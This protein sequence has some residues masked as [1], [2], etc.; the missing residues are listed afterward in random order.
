[1]KL[2]FVKRHLSITAFPEIEVPHFTVVLGINGSGKSHLLQA[3]ANGSV[4][5]DVVPFPTEHVAP[6]PIPNLIKLMTPDQFKINEG[7]YTSQAANAGMFTPFES[8]RNEILAPFLAQLEQQGLGLRKGLLDS[9]E[10]AWRVGASE[11]I[12]RGGLPEKSVEIKAIFDAAANAL[13]E[14]CNA[15]SLPGRGIARVRS[16]YLPQVAR[17][18]SKLKTSALKISEDHIRQFMP[19]TTDQFQPNLA[20]VFGKYR[21]AF[22]RNRLLRLHDIDSGN[23]NSLSDEKFVEHFG[24]PPWD[25]ISKTFS[26]FGLPYVAVAPDLFSV[27]PVTFSIAKVSSAERVAIGNMS[28][29]ERILFQFA[30]AMFHYDEEVT[31]VTR[32]KLL[33]LD[34]MDAP[35]HPEMVNRWLGAVSG[36]LVAQQGVSCILTTHSPTTIALAPEAALYQ[37]TNGHFGL[38][39]ISKQDAL[40]TLTYGV[41][42]LSIDYSGR[43]QVF[44][45]SDTDAAIFERVYSLIKSLISCDREL[46]TAQPAWS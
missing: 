38:S 45:D 2:K 28:S 46:V 14:H 9:R 41:P 44:A 10:D 16:S 18:A 22:V 23:Q 32:P 6:S 1:M 40:N 12:G 20:E 37:M 42:T 43:R 3:I 36:G 15:A 21:D 27:D 17:V 4:S 31:T 11:L 5:N 7:Q 13:L 39:R 25:Q 34:E 33:L 24:S 35:L 29:G 19:W 8:E 26:A 30:L